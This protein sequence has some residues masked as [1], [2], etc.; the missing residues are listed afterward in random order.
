MCSV[1]RAMISGFSTCEG[2]EVLEEGFFEAGSVFANGHSGGGCVADDLVVDVGDVH[3]VAG[4]DSLQLEEA[5]Q[6]VDLEERP[7]VADVAVV[8][9]GRSAGVHAER[10][11]VGGREFLD[12]AG[13]SVEE[14]D[15]HSYGGGGVQLK[16]PADCSRFLLL[17]PPGGYPLPPR[18]CTS[19][20][21]S[22][23]TG[24]CWLV[25]R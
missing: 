21:L 13:E 25:H 17:A 20:I 6:H 14:S 3:D 5:A 10:L 24:T 8:V 1:A 7:E 15:G 22:H 11:A 12:A 19:F 16:F 2:V 9:D 4:G 23:L 18:F